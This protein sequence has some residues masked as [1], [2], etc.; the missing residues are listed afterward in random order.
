MATWKLN[1]I[2]VEDNLISQAQVS[3]GNSDTTDTSFPVSNVQDL[4]VSKPGRVLNRA[5]TMKMHIAF[6]AAT[7]I[8]CIAIVGHN[9]E[10]TAT[11]NLHAGSSYD[12]AHLVTLAWRKNI[13]F[14]VFSTPQSYKYWSLN[15]SDDSNLSGFFQVGYIVMGNLTEFNFGFAVRAEF[16]NI[17]YTQRALT[18]MMSPLVR[19]QSEQMHLRLTFQN[20]PMSEMNSLRNFFIANL[21]VGKPALFIPYKEGTDCVFGHITNE[22]FDRVFSTPTLSTTTLEI[23]DCYPGN[24]SL[25]PCP[26]IEAGSPVPKPHTFTRS[27]VAYYKNSDLQLVSAA[28]N[29]LRE[30]SY[31][32]SY[33]YGIL[34]EPTRTNSWAYSEDLDSW[35][36]QEYQCSI[37][38]A[39]AGDKIKEPRVSPS[40]VGDRIQEDGSTGQHYVR[41]NTWTATSD[42]LQS[43]SFFAKAG[44]R[45]VVTTQCRKKNGTTYLRTTVDL[46]D[47]SILYNAADNCLVES[48]Y[49]GW[50]RIL[51]SYNVGIGASAPYFYIGLYNSA[52]SYTG[53]NASGLYIFG[54]QLEI[55]AR[56][57]SSYIATTASTAQRVR[58]NFYMP[59][60]LGV[61]PITLYS[62]HIEI[63]ISNASSLTIAQ[64]GTTTDPR[65][66]LTTSSTGIGRSQYDD[67]ATIVLSTATGVPSLGETTELLGSITSEPGTKISQSI[68]GGTIT[69]DSD[70]GGVFQDS[71]AE[72]IIYFGS[73]SDGTIPRTMLLQVFKAC[74]GVQSLNFMRGLKS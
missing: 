28:A 17:V 43:I 39:G 41:S 48:Y 46:S 35:D 49:D 32:N 14:H 13:I 59:F 44:E 51:I 61:Q 25:P 67:G 21:G 1:Y 19:Y 26:I 50:Y 73:R 68:N 10:D 55:D 7:S 38:P 62:K 23:E 30:L 27:S 42:T 20:R 9:L 3:T 58:D 63:D 56:F 8:N 65:F 71:F 15:V 53:D 29:E 64:I 34:L 45:T 57:P 22:S 2:N 11:I 5:S 18:D 16:S 6:P 37:N 31:L 12:P 72:D 69:S 40:T 52:T 24:I 4:P 60:D 70:S 74:R 54:T 47:G 66:E 33:Q 36:A